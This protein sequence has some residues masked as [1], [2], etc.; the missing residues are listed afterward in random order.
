MQYYNP[1]Q[2]SMQ[3]NVPQIPQQGYMPQQSAQMSSI[4]NSS[5]TWVQGD[6]G[7]RA[8]PIS[9]GSSI[10]L[11][12]SEEQN[13]YI[14]SADMTGMPSLKKYAYSE[15]INEPVRLE[16]KQS[17]DSKDDIQALRNEIKELKNKLVTIENM[18]TEQS[19]TGRT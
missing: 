8:Y 1:Y 10:L 7:A 11:M 18:K 12:D 5:I 9:P 16:S 15:V 4:P 13:F 2:M 3:Q 6:V 19:A 17:Y 14:K